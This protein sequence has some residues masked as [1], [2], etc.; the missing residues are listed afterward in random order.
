MISSDIEKFNNTIKENNFNIKVYDYRLTGYWKGKYR[1]EKLLKAD[2]K[3]KH[4]E[5]PK[6]SI[7][8]S[9]YD[10]VMKIV[11]ICQRIEL[12]MEEISTLQRKNKY[13]LFGS[14]RKSNEALIDNLA[15]KIN[16]T[17]KDN[18]CIINGDIYS[19]KIILRKMYNVK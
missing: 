17:I 2:I 13:R 8:Y 7:E 3:F 12:L 9:S 19:G 6:L 4:V 18:F 11:Y 16:E 1:D 10:D 5:L 15:S 14:T